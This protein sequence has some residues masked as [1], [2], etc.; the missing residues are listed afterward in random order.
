MAQVVRQR[1][2]FGEIFV[3]AEGAGD[4]AR[5]GSDFHRMRQA[6]A[7]MIAGAIEKDLR[8]IFEAAKRARVD[9][10][11]AIPLVVS[12]PFGRVFFEFAAAR[13]STE[14]GIRREDLPLAFFQLKARAGHWLAALGPRN[15]AALKRSRAVTLQ[16]CY[17]HV[18]LLATNSCADTPRSSNSRLIASSIRLFGHEAPAVMPTVIL[19]G[20]SQS[21]VS[22]SCC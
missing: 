14:L 15:V 3:E 19:P 12:P 8:L 13:V 18:Q 17:V 9:H 7:K 21:R 2:G 11:V 4:I 5:N 20:G 1:D 6:G 16:L 22:T 10:A